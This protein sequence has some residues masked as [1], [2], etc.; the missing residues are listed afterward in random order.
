MKSFSLIA[1]VAVAL[2]AP[3]FS[4]DITSLPQCAV[5]AS[6]VQVPR[7]LSLERERIDQTD[8]RATTATTYLGGYQQLWMPPDRHLLHLR[9]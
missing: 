3:A 4:Q 9:K 6:P 2:I 7:D 1:A 5:S 8:L